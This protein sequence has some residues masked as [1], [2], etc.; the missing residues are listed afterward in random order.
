MKALI[1]TL[2]ALSVTVAATAQPSIKKAKQDKAPDMVVG[3]SAGFGSQAQ[4]YGGSFAGYNRPLGDYFTTGAY[5]RWDFARRW[6]LQAGVQK[7]FIPPAN[8]LDEIGINGT[9]KRTQYEIPVT[10]LY[11]FTPKGA[12]LRPYVGWGLTGVITHDNWDYTVQTSNGYQRRQDVNTG[13]NLQPTANLGLNWQ[14]NKHLQLNYAIG[15]R[16]NGS[17]L[18]LGTKIGVAFSLW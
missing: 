7:N 3:L 10:M 1:C 6:G 18:N 13:F 9:L 4:H 8:T 15:A 2:T 12:A 14:V 11:Y 16:T 17:Q 5:L